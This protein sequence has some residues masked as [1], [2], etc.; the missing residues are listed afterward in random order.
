MDYQKLKK[1]IWQTMAGVI[2]LKFEPERSFTKIYRVNIRICVC[3]VSMFLYDV[4]AEKLR[5]P[6]N[7][8]V[9]LRPRALDKRECLMI[10]VIFLIDH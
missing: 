6:T 3:H 8:W 9:T 1:N 10:H 7:S 4:R 5:D 2:V